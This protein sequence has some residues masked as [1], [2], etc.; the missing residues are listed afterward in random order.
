MSARG[1]APRASDM[2]LMAKEYLWLRGRLETI[3]AHA[4]AED[5][6]LRWIAD[7]L[8]D[9]LDHFTTPLSASAT[10]A[11]GLGGA[12]EGTPAPPQTPARVDLPGGG[13]TGPD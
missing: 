6:T 2:V 12:G 13:L 4:A 9:A 10:A 11:A 5:R 3:A 8:V 1:M 7:E